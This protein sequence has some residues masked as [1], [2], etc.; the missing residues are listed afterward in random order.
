MRYELKLGNNSEVLKTMEDNSI[1]SIVTDPPYEIAFMGRGWDA[2]GVAHNV[3]LW[4][5][6]LRVLKPGGYLLA[7]GATRTYHRLVCAIE[8]SGFEIKNQLMWVFGTGFPKGL[9]IGKAIDE[10]FGLEREVIGKRVFPDGSEARATARGGIF[11]KISIGQATITAPASPEATK[12]EGWN[13]GLKPAFEPICMAQK[14]I[15]GTYVDNILKWG[16]GALNIDGC[17]IG[18]EPGDSIFAKNPHTVGGFG[19]AD[20]K[21]YVDSDG[22]LFSTSNGRYPSNLIIDDSEEVSDLFPC[23]VGYLDSNTSASRFFYC[24]KASKKDRNEGTDRNIHP[25]VKPTDLMQ[26]LIRLVTPKN[27]LVLDPFNGSG[28]TGK[29]CMYEGMR[30]VGIDI[31]QEY[32]DISKGRIEYAIENAVPPELKESKQPSIKKPVNNKFIVE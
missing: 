18:I 12:W 4:K 16:V 9:E 21:V 3:D 2:S 5:E 17:R 1:D 11:S 26:Y 13:T 29:A 24:A 7:F 10:K 25:T 22:S 31:N 30:Y 27:G 14:P 32:L 19:H 8:D 15:D 23:S 6:C 20:A 28:S